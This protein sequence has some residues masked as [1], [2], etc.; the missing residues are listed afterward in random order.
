MMREMMDCAC[1]YFGLR[2]L[3]IGGED[4]HAMRERAFGQFSHGKAIF[5]ADNCVRS[6]SMQECLLELF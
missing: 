3:T 6:E 2:G 4:I 1:M 5:C